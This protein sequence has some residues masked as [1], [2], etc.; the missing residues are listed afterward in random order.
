MTRHIAVVGAG[1]VGS[2]W[3]I[4]FA[5]AGLLVRVF[6]E[7]QAI[8]ERLIQELKVNLEDLA[9]YGLVEDARRSWVESMFA[10]RSSRQYAA[11][12]MSR[13]RFWSGSM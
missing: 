13:S 3:A 9:S 4:V 11:P 8:R 10:N 6:D 5:R 12:A 7:N 2:G 1:L